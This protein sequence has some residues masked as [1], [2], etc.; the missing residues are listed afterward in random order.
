MANQNPD[1]TPNQQQQREE[2]QRRKQQQQQQGGQNRQPGA[3]RPDKDR[4]DQ[5]QR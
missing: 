1:Q 5:Q 3:E 4:D 2:E